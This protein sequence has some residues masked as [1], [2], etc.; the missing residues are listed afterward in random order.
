MKRGGTEMFIHRVKACE[1]RS[2]MIGTNGDH[3][4]KP[5]GRIHGVPPTYPVPELEHVSAVDAEL[6]DLGSIS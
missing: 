2:E 3:G 6:H 1:H 4:R 5:D